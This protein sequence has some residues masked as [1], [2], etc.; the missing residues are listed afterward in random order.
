[1][2]KQRVNRIQNLLAQVGM[3]QERIRMFN[4]SSAMANKF[5]AA[6]T[7]MVEQVMA[8]GPSPLGIARHEGGSV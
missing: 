8:L 3:E 5:A 7:E 1:M 4:M 6:A 2:A